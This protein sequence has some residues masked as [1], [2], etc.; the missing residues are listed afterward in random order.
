[1]DNGFGHRS[2]AGGGFEAHPSRTVILGLEL[3]SLLGGEEMGIAKLCSNQAVQ[4]LE[5]SG[6]RQILG[7][8]LRL[9]PPDEAQVGAGFE[10]DRADRQLL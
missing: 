8:V 4:F 2:S 7:D 10:H 1:M 6:N 3:S 9:V 5:C